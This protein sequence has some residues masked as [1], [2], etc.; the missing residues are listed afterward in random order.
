MTLALGNITL[1]CTDPQTVAAFW[2]AALD[3]QIDAGA[4]PFFVSIG[5]ADPSRTGMFFIAVPEPK[6]GKNR[7]HADLHAEDREAEVQRLLA[8][9]ATRRRDHD[10]YGTRWTT[11]HDVEG[12]EFCVAAG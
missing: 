3:R 12:N 9:G 1:D 4:S 7:V 8:L 2:S 5:R 10:E 11:M 6:A